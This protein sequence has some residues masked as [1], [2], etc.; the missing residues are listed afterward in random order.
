MHA[1][2]AAVEEAAAPGHDT[3]VIRLVASGPDFCAGGDL[4]EGAEMIGRGDGLGSVPRAMTDSVQRL[5]H[6]LWSTKLP[7][8]V[9]VRGRAIGL[10][11]AL[12]L[13]SDL[14]I[15]G[16]SA[17]FR[18]P[19]TQRGFTPDSGVSWMLPRVIGLARATRTLFL[20]EEIDANTAFAL[21]LVNE[22]V[23]DDEVEALVDE[24]VGR[25]AVGATVAL[26]YTKQLIRDGLDR[27]IAESLAAEVDAMGACMPTRDFREGFDAFL[28]HRGARFEGR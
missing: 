20:D 9:G 21:G 10:G 2:I 24:W 8:V 13:V 15:A 28:E 19:F 26:G 22:V 1:V 23:R 25:L 14:A 7:M 5:V 27:A 11:A 16:T 3:R 12:V 18:F 17:R 6:T 4:V